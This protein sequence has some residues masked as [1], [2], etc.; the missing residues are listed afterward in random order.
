MGLQ[1]LTSHSAILRGEVAWTAKNI[2]EGSIDRLKA[3][4]QKDPNL[5]PTISSQKTSG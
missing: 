2:G 4:M 1:I 3:D 5:T